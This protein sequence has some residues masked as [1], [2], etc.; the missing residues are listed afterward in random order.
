[1]LK[2]LIPILI[3]L[4]L[5]FIVGLIFGWCFGRISSQTEVAFAIEKMCQ[6]GN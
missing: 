4:T 3:A 1:M 6:H 5:S 2:I